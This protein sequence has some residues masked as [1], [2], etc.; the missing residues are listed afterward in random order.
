MF[1]DEN[2]GLPDETIHH[3]FDDEPSLNGKGVDELNNDGAEQEEDKESYSKKVQK[4]IDKLTAKNY[5][6][7]S[8]LQAERKRRQELEDRLNEQER[9]RSN[10][11]IQALRQRKVDLMSEGEFEEAAKVDDEIIDLRLKTTQKAP[12]VGQEEQS[13]VAPTDAEIR[14]QNRNDW[15]FNPA[16]K[17]KQQEAINGYRALVS[18]GFDPE[19]DDFYDE[20]D[21][22]LNKSSDNVNS[23]KD[24]KSR[25]QQRQPVPA[26]IGPDRGSAVGDDKSVKF[27]NEDAATMR[28]WGLDPNNAKVRAEYL[29]NKGS[30]V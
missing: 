4:R 11:H 29:R 23:E 16:K 24:D 15:W 14:W 3:T 22:L 17:D 25:N 21:R 26:G 13:Y 9:E 5:Q 27:T 1:D 19:D 18:E 30:G 12:N 28:R 7:D 8:E 6:I 2:V 20:L 10:A